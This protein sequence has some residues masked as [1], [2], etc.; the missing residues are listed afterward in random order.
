[1]AIQLAQKFDGE[2]VCADS[3]TVYRGM[4]IGTAKPSHQDQKAVRHH[5]LD[6]F[7]P[8]KP[9]G[10]A[11]FKELAQSAITEIQSRGK[12]PFLVGGSGMYIDSVLYDY[13]FRDDMSENE[14]ED[15]SN[16]SLSDL[17]KIAGEK[18]PKQFQQIDSKNRR[19]VEQLI[20]KGPSKDN[21][22]KHNEVS[23]L[24]LGIGIEKPILKQ[25]IDART[26]SMLSNNFIHEVELLRSK[27]GDTDILLHTTGYAQ[28][29]DYLEGKI[30]EVDLH[31]AICTATYQLSRKQMTWFRRNAAIQWIHTLDQA[32]SS[33]TKYLTS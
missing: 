23:S 20:S 11:Q 33:I 19:R 12:L 29:I 27:Y 14:R 9:V 2:I 28:V 30:A 31:S 1:M 18:Y 17:Q 4:D 3:R 22:R 32:S 26:E 21:D 24:V 8:N 7:E 13:T 6:L 10:A 5:L 25:N 15:L 16:L